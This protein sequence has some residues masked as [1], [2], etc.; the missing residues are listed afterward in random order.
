[1]PWHRS[2]SGIRPFFTE[3]A[4]NGPTMTVL[5]R[6]AQLAVAA[7][8]L[9][10]GISGYGDD[11]TPTSKLTPE[12]ELRQDN[13]IKDGIK[14]KLGELGP[15]TLA[16][17]TESDKSAGLTFHYSPY[18]VGPLPKVPTPYSFRGRTSGNIYRPMA[19]RSSAARDPRATK[20]N[21]DNPPPPQ[22]LPS[23]HVQAARRCAFIQASI[24]RSA[25]AL[26]KP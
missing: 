20:I 24:S 4:D 11:D 18:G 10:N 26:A 19:R 7:A 9:A 23:T 5:A 12:Q 21:G 1:M 16:A 6:L 22:R 17:S 2:A 15:V 3:T 14:P 25:S 8:K 13:F